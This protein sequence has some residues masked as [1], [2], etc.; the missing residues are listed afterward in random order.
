MSIAMHCRHGGY[1]CGCWA[2]GSFP[3][4]AAPGMAAA[5][6]FEA[7][8]A[9]RCSKEKYVSMRVCEVVTSKAYA[10]SSQWSVSV[11]IGT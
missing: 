6:R 1:T 11:S 4:C 10:V 8:L 5:R 2:C 7:N 3:G 9:K